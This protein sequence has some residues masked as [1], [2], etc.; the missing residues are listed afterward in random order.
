LTSFGHQTKNGHILNM[1]TFWAYHGV[2][3]YMYH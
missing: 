2:L 1:N 3:C